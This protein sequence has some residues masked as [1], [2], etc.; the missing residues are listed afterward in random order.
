M[1]GGRR[2]PAKRVR[3][4]LLVLG[5]GSMEHLGDEGGAAASGVFG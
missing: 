4:D 2:K 3:R 5:V 1:V